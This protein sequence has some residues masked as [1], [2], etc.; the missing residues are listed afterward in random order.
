[1]VELRFNPGSHVRQDLSKVPLVSYSD[2]IL[3][4]SFFYVK[5][6]PP[7]SFCM[8]IG[9]SWSFSVCEYPF[10]YPWKMFSFKTPPPGR[11]G[12]VVLTFLT[13]QTMGFLW[14][15][16]GLIR[17]LPVLSRRENWAFPS[18]KPYLCLTLPRMLCLA[19]S[20]QLWG[21]LVSRT[22]QVSGPGMNAGSLPCPEKWAH[23][24]A[25][26]EVAVRQTGLEREELNFTSWINTPR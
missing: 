25:L 16:P 18:Q 17:Q 19:P 5:S 23:N 22:S 9:K 1:M 20:R 15:P 8:E 21:S 11:V 24:R 7:A 12:S 10:T 4:L 13:F 2:M 14:G 3:D 6:L 26:L